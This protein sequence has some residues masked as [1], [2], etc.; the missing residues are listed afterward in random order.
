VNAAVAE[1]GA[2]VVVLEVDG[3]RLE[4]HRLALRDDCPCPDCRHPLSGQ[5]LFDSSAT[6]RHARPAGVRVDGDSL[7]VT[8]NDGHQSA[9]AGEWLAAELAAQRSLA[10]PA[11]RQARWG[12]ELAATL[13]RARFDDVVA[14]AAVRR[15]WLEDVASYGFALLEGVPTHDGAVAEVAELFGHVRTTNYGRVFDVRVRVHA[16]NLADTTMAL[17]LH[18]DNPYREPVPT[19]QLLHCLSSDADGGETVLADGFRAVERLAARAPHLLRLLAEQPIRY[20]Y[21]DA[22]A[23]LWADVPV[24]VLDADGHPAA[25]HVNNRSKGTPV[26]PASLVGEWYE[27]YFALLDE[28]ASPG[29]RVTFRL[30]PGDLVAFDNLRVLHGRTGFSSEGDRRLQGCYADRDALH[31]AIAILDRKARA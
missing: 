10:R 2:D 21:R 16:A 7:L 6:L 13:P 4:L 27:A 19:V 12:A 5:R 24:V 25:L 29:A 3:D 14:A 9:Y 8:W 31:S 26:G 17:G 18:T 11:R 23:E 28:L 20:A 1:I 15:R 30:E 22:D